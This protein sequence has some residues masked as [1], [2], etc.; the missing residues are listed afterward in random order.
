[1]DRWKEGSEDELAYYDDEIQDEVHGIPRS[2]KNVYSRRKPPAA[3]DEFNLE[4][5]ME[6]FMDAE[7]DDEDAMDEEEE[8]LEEYRK[9]FGQSSNLDIISEKPSDEAD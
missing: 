7:Y 6:R 8:M 2:R 5:D 4:V 1:M 9:T 3:L